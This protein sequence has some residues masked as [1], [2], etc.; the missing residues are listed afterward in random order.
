MRNHQSRKGYNKIP[1]SEYKE[2]CGQDY[3]D[4]KVIGGPRNQYCFEHRGMS[5]SERNM[6]ARRLKAL[7]DRG[8]EDKFQDW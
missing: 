2:I 4:R 7:Q 8:V 3:C 5:P 1:E 6:E